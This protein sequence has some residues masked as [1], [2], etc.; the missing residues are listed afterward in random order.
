M[1]TKQQIIWQNLQITFE[2][3]IIY[4]QKI[5]NK[6]HA[7][8]SVKYLCNSIFVPSFRSMFVR[9][10]LLSSFFHFYIYFS[11]KIS[12]Y[13]YAGPWWCE[14]ESFGSKRGPLE[15]Q[16][17]CFKKDLSKERDTDTLNLFSIFFSMVRGQV[18]FRVGIK[19]KI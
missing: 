13:T 17:I 18:L 16:N 15:P 10:N 4:L 2:K 8:R 1:T 6:Q 11:L 12:S 3:P 7:T 5:C 9:S 14:A 19:S